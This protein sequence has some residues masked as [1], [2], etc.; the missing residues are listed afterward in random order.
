L[1]PVENPKNPKI[2]PPPNPEPKL[3]GKLD[4]DKKNSFGFTTLPVSD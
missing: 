1:P 2:G 4:P 3:K